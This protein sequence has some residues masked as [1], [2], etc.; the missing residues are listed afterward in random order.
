MMVSV[1]FVTM[2]LLSV[3]MI[4][5]DHITVPGSYTTD[6]C[7]RG[8]SQCDLVKVVK[9]QVTPKANSGSTH[10]YQ[11]T[12]INCSMNASLFDRRP[13]YVFHGLGQEFHLVLRP[14]MVTIENMQRN[15]SL[16]EGAACFYSGHVRGEK[17]SSVA[18]SLCKGMVSC[19][20]KAVY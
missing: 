9:L 10:D 19:N 1:K 16:P 18:V 4:I 3:M 11:H 17:M 7:W 20:C 14:D 6:H 2:L 5:P 13:E 8:G 15:L 12:F